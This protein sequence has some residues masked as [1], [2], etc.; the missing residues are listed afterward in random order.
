MGQEP[1]RRWAE[2]VL[3]VE[4][5][6][7]LRELIQCVLETEGVVVATAADGQAAVEYLERE[8]PALI[9]LDRELP[10][11]DGVAVAARL[12]AAHGDSLRIIAMTAASSAAEFAQEVGAV[13]YLQKPF[14]VDN[15]IA[16]VR[17]LVPAS[18]NDELLVG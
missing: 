15:L 1:P 18:R 11:L 9:L 12:R 3:V 14:D 4:D 5:D 17:R 6:P 8:S 16:M 10:V 7:D 2:P 13:D